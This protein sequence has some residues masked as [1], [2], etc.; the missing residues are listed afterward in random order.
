M[1]STE[2]KIV[3]MVGKSL[4]GGVTSYLPGLFM[5]K[6]WEIRPSLNVA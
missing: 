6:I 2:R 3:E 1:E 5:M 4:V